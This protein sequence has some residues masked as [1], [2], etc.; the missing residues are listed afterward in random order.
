ML[1]P[2]FPLTKT[3]ASSDGHIACG[4]EFALG[5]DPLIRWED[6]PRRGRCGTN[7]ASGAAGSLEEGVCQEEREQTNFIPT[8]QKWI[9]ASEPSENG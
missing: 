8:A 7:V 6:L 4:E 9:C 1:R 3:I 2:T 5:D